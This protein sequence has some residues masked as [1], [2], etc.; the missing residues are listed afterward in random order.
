MRKHSSA[1]EIKLLQ[2]YRCRQTERYGAL[3]RK[4]TG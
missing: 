4:D 3:A 2:W 1:A